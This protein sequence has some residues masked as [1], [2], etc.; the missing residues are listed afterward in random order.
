MIDI[1]EKISAAIAMELVDTESIG[2]NKLKSEE[3]KKKKK[4]KQYPVD[5]KTNFMHHV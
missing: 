1:E 3:N 4:K 5:S 2:R